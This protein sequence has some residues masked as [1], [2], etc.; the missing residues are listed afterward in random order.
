MY[1]DVMNFLWTHFFPEE[2]L[3]RSL[4]ITRLPVIDKYFFPDVFRQNCSMA[5]VDSSGNILAV[6][7]GVIKNKSNWNTWLQDKIFEVLPYKLL[8]RWWPSLEKGP[9]FIKV[10]KTID[11]NVWTR[12]D[13][14]NCQS[15]YEV[16]KTGEFSASKLT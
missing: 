1:E 15:V 10:Q 7:V 6:R 12:F 14:W 16:K 2:P 5:A 3:C 13:G 4:G 8:S 11:F 9:I